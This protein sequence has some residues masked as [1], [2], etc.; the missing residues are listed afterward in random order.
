MKTQH[1]KR[2]VLAENLHATAPTNAFKSWMSK[3]KRMCW[4]CQKDKPLS[5]GKLTKA[6][7]SKGRTP[8]STI[9]KFICG[10]CVALKG[11]A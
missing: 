11:V 10:D 6:N 1:S 7:G 4:K 3:R 9:D 5:G 8:F 2:D